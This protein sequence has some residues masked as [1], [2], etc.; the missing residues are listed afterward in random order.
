MHRWV[1]VVYTLESHI[2]CKIQKLDSLLVGNPIDKPHMYH[3]CICIPF[4]RVCNFFRIQPSNNSKQQYHGK[5]LNHAQTHTLC[6]PKKEGGLGFMKLN[7]WY[8][9]KLMGK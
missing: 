4:Y 6:C 1:C 5:D 7:D 2:N 8:I 3:V 9:S